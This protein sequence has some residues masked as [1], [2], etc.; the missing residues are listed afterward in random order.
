MILSRA[1]RLRLINLSAIVLAGF[2][3]RLALLNLGVETDP[4][5]PLALHLDDVG[6]KPWQLLRFA[7][8]TSH[9]IRLPQSRYS[10]SRL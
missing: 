1:A 10:A 6:E 7:S 2:V 3:L 4:R 5:F 8:L 9:N